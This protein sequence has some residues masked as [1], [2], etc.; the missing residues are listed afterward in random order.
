MKAFLT[1][2]LFLLTFIGFAQD[3]KVKPEIQQAEKQL[4]RTGNDLYNDENYIDAEVQY[5]K[6]LEL[7]PNYEKANYN[8][9]NAIYQQNRFKEALPLYDLVSKTTESKLNKAESFH[10]IG[11]TMMKEKQYDKA[12]EAYKNALRNNHKDDETRY[13]LALAQ[14]MLEEQK[15]QNKDKDQDN[16]DNKDNKDQDNKDQ[17]KKED[18]NKD[19]ENEDKEDKKPENKDENKDKQEPKPQQ[20]KLTPQQIKQLLE[21]MN[22]EEN[23]T[24]QKV[25]AQKAKGS[26]VKQEKDW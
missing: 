20:N 1:Y 13:N 9:G 14:K 21:A 15:N 10:N 3:K 19:K 18:Q 23:K 26:K 5:K 24:Q 25:N 2:L 4:F 7:N 8:L 6:A 22:N 16:K 11:N 12:I 17:D